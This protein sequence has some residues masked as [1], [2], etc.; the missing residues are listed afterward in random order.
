MVT[1][2]NDCLKECPKKGILLTMKLKKAQAFF[3]DGFAR[4]SAKIVCSI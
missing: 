1:K 2:A 4:Q 3:L